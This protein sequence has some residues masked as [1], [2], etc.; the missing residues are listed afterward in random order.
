[1]AHPSSHVFVGT[2]SLSG[3][4]AHYAKRFDLLEVSAEPG[5]HPRGSGLA[6]WRKT[7]PSEFVF[8]VVLPPRLAALEAGPDADSLIEHSRSVA[9]A[10]GA[11]WWVVRTPPTVTPS[12]RNTR[13]L[14][15]LVERLRGADRRIAWEPRGIWRAEEALDTARSLDVHWVQDLARE[16]PG[17]D[18]DVVYTRLRALGEGVRIGAAAAERVAERLADARLGYVIVEGAGAARIRQALRDV[19][20]MDEGGPAT[21]DGGEEDEDFEDTEGEDD[22]DEEA[23]DQED[24]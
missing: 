1:M 12:T 7:V 17:S 8:S 24:A 16:E 19:L 9:D 20:G 2:A 4:I 23:E 13:A 5:K 6:T 18:S 15:A 11:G 10:L 14:A 21:P 3:S 22:F